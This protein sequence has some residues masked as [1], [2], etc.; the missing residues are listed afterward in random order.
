MHGIHHSQVQRET[1]SNYGVV[2]PWW[3]RLH[4]T[5]GL[6]VP[7]SAITIGVP[8]YSNPEDNRLRDA[9][10]LPFRK[11]RDY[12]R[13]PDGIPVTRDARLEKANRHR[14]AE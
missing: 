9:I 13:R 12:W 8:A 7:Q 3:D 10:L 14:L 4:R 2:L 5:L 11:Q 1:N 6:N